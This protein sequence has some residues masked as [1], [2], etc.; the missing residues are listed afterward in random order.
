MYFC[1]WA[2]SF[3]QQ[4]VAFE[5]TAIKKGQAMNARKK[6]R[7]TKSYIGMAL[8]MLI[9]GLSFVFVKMALK[10]ASP[11]DVLAHRFTAAA[12]CMA[13][14]CA[15]G[16]TGIPHISKHQTG[17]LLLLSV[18]Y[19][20]LFFALQTAGLQYTTASEAG[21]LSAVMP[22][23]T[24]IAAALLLKEKSTWGQVAGI[25]VSIGG[26]LYIFYKN[27]VAVQTESLKG[28]LFIIACVLAN[29]AY[30]ILGR[31][32]NKGF[33]A[34]DITFFMMLAACVV[35]NAMALFQHSAN[36]DMGAFLK[37]LIHGEFVFSVLYL[38]VLSSL[39]TSLF[40]NYALSAIPASQVAAFT[41][42]SPIVT[43]VGGALILDEQL[44]TYQIVGGLLVIAGV[45]AT[46]LFKK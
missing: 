23:L 18:F 16:R 9:I 29:V 37:P 11:S 41:N 24:L 34:A 4:T 44:Q 42:L 20:F 35:F 32:I 13:A 2:A 39:V 40:S 31:R 36:G 28:N 46:M 15:V 8:S 5:E 10:Y 25:V 22:V 12:V 43:I 17:Q 33:K 14:V 27:G 6:N 7:E 26:I 21:I 1:T 3:V 30:Y 19:P 38:G 45:L